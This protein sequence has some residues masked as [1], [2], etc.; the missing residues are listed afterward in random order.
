MEDVVR[1]GSKIE[2]L[3]VET[4]DMDGDSPRTPGGEQLLIAFCPSCGWPHVVAESER[5][6]AVRIKC[7]NPHCGCEIERAA[8]AKW[9]P[10]KPPPISRVPE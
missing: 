1:F 4:R 2:F 10:P 5:P 9:L 3:K 6:E 7:Q 8:F